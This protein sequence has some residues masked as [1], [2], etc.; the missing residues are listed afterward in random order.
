MCRNIVWIVWFDLV[1]I[2][3]SKVYARMEINMKCIYFR[4]GG[5]KGAPLLGAPNWHYQE[6]KKKT[7]DRPTDHFL[8]H[9]ESK[10]DFL[11][12]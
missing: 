12:L 2:I 5:G 9:A 1:D 8:Y 4:R 7:D 6:K 3:W 11:G 10:L